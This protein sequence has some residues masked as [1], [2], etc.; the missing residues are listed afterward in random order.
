VAGFAAVVPAASPPPLPLG[1]GGVARL[2]SVVRV[3]DLEDTRSPR[4]GGGEM[5]AA[6]RA[7]CRTSALD[8]AVVNRS[9][10]ELADEEK[11]PEGAGQPDEAPAHD[12]AP[13]HGCIAAPDGLGVDPSLLEFLKGDPWE[14]CDDLAE[15]GFVDWCADIVRL[16]SSNIDEDA[17][18]L[19]AEFLADGDTDG[20]STRPNTLAEMSSRSSMDSTSTAARSLPNDTAGPR[21]RPATGSC[22]TRPRK[23]ANV[24]SVT[25]PAVS[26]SPT[27][28]CSVRGAS[29]Q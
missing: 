11:L 15:W 3:D 4:K 1:A 16:K 25:L 12:G 28:A 23:S 29:L 6:S 8:F 14:G 19:L 7:T 22:S 17:T 5:A 9:P 21:P 27:W 18:A 24:A 10:A 13:A 26:S 20:G 2:A